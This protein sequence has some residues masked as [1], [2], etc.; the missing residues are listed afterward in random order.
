M[1]LATLRQDYSLAVLAEQCNQATPHRK[2]VAR[3]VEVAKGLTR[4][5]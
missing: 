5:I 3:N 1:R 2:E 4:T